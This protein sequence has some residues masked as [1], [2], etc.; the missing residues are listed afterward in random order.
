MGD[1]YDLS[2]VF[3][4]KQWYVHM[5]PGKNIKRKANYKII[6]ASTW[7]LRGVVSFIKGIKPQA[8]LGDNNMC[9]A[10]II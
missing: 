2:K 8:I 10:G 1:L 4:H 7:N 9:M 3:N 5:R 6:L